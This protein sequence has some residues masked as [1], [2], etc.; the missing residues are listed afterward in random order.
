MPG[1]IA[2]PTREEIVRRHE[3]GESLRRIAEDMELFLDGAQGVAS[4]SR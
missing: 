2:Q 1:V 3:Q 4:L